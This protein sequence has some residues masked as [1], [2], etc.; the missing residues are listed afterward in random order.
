MSGA[1]S[2]E[3]LLVDVPG[4][5]GDAAVE[6]AEI[7]EL[8]A[9]LARP[10][11]SPPRKKA[12]RKQKKEVMAG[13]RAKTMNG[14]GKADLKVRGQEPGFDQVGSGR[15]RILW[16]LDRRGILLRSTCTV[17]FFIHLHHLYYTPP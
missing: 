12:V 10:A 13:T 5:A 11:D 8:Q 15:W 9:M 17:R 4:G 3:A 6:G 7:A 16:E 1:S 14:Q 2:S